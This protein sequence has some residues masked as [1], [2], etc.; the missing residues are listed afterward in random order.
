MDILSALILGVIQGVTEFLPI[1][2]T[3]HLILVRDALNM[4]GE[5]ALAFDAALHLATLAAVASYFR[6]DIVG[7]A[8]TAFAFVSRT[9]TSET[10]R[11]MLIAV[12]VGTIPAAVIGFL[13]RDVIEVSLRAPVVVASGLLAG[14]ILMYVAERLVRSEAVSMTPKKG[15]AIGCFQAL[16][17]IPGMSRSGSTIAGGLVNGLSRE[18]ATRFAFVLSF[19]ILLGAGLFSFMDLLASG[20]PGALSSALVIAMAA[21]FVSGLLAIHY[22][23]SYLKRH[24]LAVF[25]W[26][27][28]AL[29]VVI[30]TFTLMG[31][32]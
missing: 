9:Q 28:V 16:A 1:S 30:I 23:V 29:A 12:I 17:L 3:G 4:A 25:I 10:E 20:D 26:Y 6:K 7:L 15:F 27:R 2:S 21:A 31:A 18:E 22:L 13:F 8:K 19:P 14:S 32:F 5:N 11:N 24:T